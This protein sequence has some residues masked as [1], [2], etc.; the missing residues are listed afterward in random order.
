MSSA[1]CLRDQS[2]TMLIRD[3]VLRRIATGEITLAFRRWRRPT[4]R[5]GG[6]LRTRV[7]VLAIEDMSTVA[8]DEIPEED[9]RMAGFSSVEA[10]RKDLLSQSEGM[11][12]R[13]QLSLAGPDP[14]VDLSQQDRLAAEDFEAIGAALRNLDG[15][16]LLALQGHPRRRAAELSQYLECDK[17][18]VKR[19]MRKLK[20]LGLI[21]SDADGYTL[22][23]RGKTYL[24]GAGSHERTSRS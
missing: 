16:L 2:Q 18:S 23:P 8:M 10:L 13:I 4:V 12:Y 11:I 7:G 24:D 21:L 3:S 5:S 19:K 1:G 15:R 14:R 20:E 9:A 6:R 22:S 17:E